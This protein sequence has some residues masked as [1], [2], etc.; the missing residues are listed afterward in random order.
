MTK[1]SALE[2]AERAKRVPYTDEQWARAPTLRA[3]MVD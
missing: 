1:S 3:G 2:A